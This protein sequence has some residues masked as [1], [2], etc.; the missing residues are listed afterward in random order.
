MPIR[1]IQ[2]LLESEQ[3]EILAAYRKRW[4]NM[5]VGG[6]LSDWMAFLPGME[7]RRA[8]AMKIAGTDK[9]E[10]KGYTGA[11]AALMMRD[12]LYDETQLERLTG[13][14]CSG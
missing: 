13:P 12:G 11:L 3:R 1:S 9:P 5:G 6:H 8:I 7:L 2:D 14:R 10:G 4:K